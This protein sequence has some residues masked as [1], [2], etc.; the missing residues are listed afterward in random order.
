MGLPRPMLDWHVQ[1]FREGQGQER[2]AT[3]SSAREAMDAANELL[4]TRTGD[5]VLVYHR[6][7]SDQAFMRFSAAMETDEVS[8][9]AAQL[10]QHV[11]RAAQ[12]G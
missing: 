10:E 12:A 2:P 7:Y 11:R 8:R 3:F 5:E 6:L 1:S 9:R 4:Q